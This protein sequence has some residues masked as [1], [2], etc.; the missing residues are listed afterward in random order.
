MNTH[1]AKKTNILKTRDS[2]PRWLLELSKTHDREA[3]VSN[4]KVVEDALSSMTLCR[5]KPATQ[6]EARFLRQFAHLPLRM[7]P[8]G[9]DAS[10]RF[11]GPQL[12]RYAFMVYD[13]RSRT[14]KTERAAAW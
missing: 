10:P 14:G 11:D 7:V 6:E 9:E 13:G 3:E 1:T 12:R 4:K 5:F 8:A 2:V